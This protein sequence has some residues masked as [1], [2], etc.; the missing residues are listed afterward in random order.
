MYS[1]ACAFI[2]RSD[3]RHWRPNYSRVLGVFAATALSNLYYPRQSRG[4]R[5]TL[6]NGAVE[7]AG[8]AGTNIAREFILKEITSN[9]GANPDIPLTWWGAHDPPQALLLPASLIVIAQVIG[10]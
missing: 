4:V 7:L 10:N 2:T 9:A 3:N 5:L 8:N 1:I 6:A